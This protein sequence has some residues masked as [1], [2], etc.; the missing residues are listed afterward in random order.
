MYGNSTM[1]HNKKLYK[2]KDWD[3]RERLESKY[4][5]EYDQST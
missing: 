1:K 4:R 5:V 2:K 3:K